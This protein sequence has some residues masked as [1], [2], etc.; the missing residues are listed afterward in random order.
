MTSADDRWLAPGFVPPELYGSRRDKLQA[1]THF[2][3]TGEGP[4]VLLL[5]GVGLDLTMWDPIVPDLAKSFTVIRYDLLGHGES[6]KPFVQVA[7]KDFVLQLS[8]MVTY[9]QLERFAL[10]GFSMGALI[11]RAYA[12]GHSDRLARLALLNSV[13]ERSV[14]QRA[15]VASRLATAE[16][17]GPQEIIDAAITRWFTEAFQNS[18]PAVIDSVRARL[19][20]N[21]RLGFLSAY[22]VFAETDGSE[23]S[24]PAAIACPTLVMTGALDSGSTPAMTHALAAVIPDAKALVLDDLAHM[25]PV[26]GAPAVAAVLSDFLKDGLGR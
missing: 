7:L 22:R 4:A 5:H 25:A 24:D 11:A 20:A 18:N 19:E 15:A 13:Y 3:V 10:V 21:D 23:T 2:A 12:A 6:A 17:E 8:A 26:E 9:F 14:E 16:Q 1:G